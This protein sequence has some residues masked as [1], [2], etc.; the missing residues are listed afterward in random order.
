MGEGSEGGPGFSLRGEE[1]ADGVRDK[2]ERREVYDVT[3][4]LVEA[5]G[6]PVI[7]VGDAETNEMLR[8]KK[9]P[10]QTCRIALM[11]TRSRGVAF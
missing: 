5:S 9:L 7:E 11:R 1:S 6:L 2:K 10:S 3:K 4:G 8:D